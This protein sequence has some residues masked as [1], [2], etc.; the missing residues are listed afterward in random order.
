VVKYVGRMPCFL[1]AAGI[2]YAMI[3]TMMFWQPNPNQIYMLFII[4]AFWGLGDAVWQTQINGGF[5][6]FFFS[7]SF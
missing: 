2:N 4:P 5:E 7:I 1:I 6:I 3:L